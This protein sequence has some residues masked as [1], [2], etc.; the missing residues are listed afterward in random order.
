[1]LPQGRPAQMDIELNRAGTSRTCSIGPTSPC[2]H[3]QTQR[4][5]PKRSSWPAYDVDG[6][7]R[8]KGARGVRLRVRECSPVQ[9]RPSRGSL[10]RRN[11]RQHV[12]YIEQLAP[13]LWCE[14]VYGHVT[15]TTTRRLLLPSGLLP[16]SSDR[17]LST[18]LLLLVLLRCDLVGS[19]VP[20][21]LRLSRR[22]TQEQNISKRGEAVTNLASL[23]SSRNGLLGRLRSSISRLVLL[24]L[25][26][27]IRGGDVVLLGECLR[28]LALSL[29][30]GLRR[31]S[32]TCSHSELQME[33]TMP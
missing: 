27:V 12:R 10:P 25:V 3:R 14:C 19:D 2:Q 1:M 23:P 20:A 6:L 13:R 24:A 15:H 30:R 8:R 26:L 17:F 28:I 32:E 29:Q 5:G 7:S 4:V 11:A 9:M 21:I 18:L 33:P 16:P 22:S 31:R